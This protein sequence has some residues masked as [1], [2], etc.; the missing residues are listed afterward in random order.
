MS[1]DTADSDDDLLT[2]EEVAKKLKV[3]PRTVLR[4]LAD[5]E[6]PAAINRVNLKRFDWPAVKKALAD[7]AA[8]TS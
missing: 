3:H 8:K 5:G 6:I 1:T 2:T 4:L 7:D